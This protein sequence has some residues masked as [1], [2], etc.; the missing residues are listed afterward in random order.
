LR[1]YRSSGFGAIQACNPPD[2]YW[3]LALPFKALGVRFV[4]DQHDL[5]PE[6]FAARFGDRRRIL[7]G[8]VRQFERATY[9]VADR[10]IA[11]NDSYRAM[12]IGRGRRDPASVVVVRSGPNVDEMR[13]GEPVPELRTGAAHLL[14]YLG[15]M[16]PQD[17][18]DRLLRAV[19][20]LVH[21]RGRTDVHVA[22]LGFGDCFDELRSLSDE[23]GLAPWVTFTGRA[24]RTM[25]GRYLSTAAIGLS[26]DPKSTFNDLST[27][28][29][30]LEYMAHE[31]AIV[32]FDLKETRVS[33]GDA[34]EYVADD[35]L[36]G[37][38]AAIDKLLDDPERRAAMGRVGRSRIE[39]TLGWHRQVA[40]YVGVYE[41]LLGAGSPA[42]RRRVEVNT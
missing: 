37:F 13:R 9:R 30:V 23:L 41:E 16:G 29:K 26:P 40:A 21:E 38:A 33:A 39:S 35:D 22:L 6:V 10:V 3:A 4:F 15:I 11:T 24:D 36:P 27:M 31:L 2:T 5:C 19:D 42:P 12:A 14:V 28:N 32:A 1:C 20:V 34:A 25:V 8:A 18:V 17:G 7:A